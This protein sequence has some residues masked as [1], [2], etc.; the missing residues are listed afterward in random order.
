MEGRRQ[1]MELRH[2][3]RFHAMKSIQAGIRHWQHVVLYAWAVT[4]AESQQE[5][6]HMRQLE[7]L[8]A[9]ENAALEEA[10][11]EKAA[12]EQALVAESCRVDLQLKE[13]QHIWRAAEQTQTAELE[14]PTFAEACHAE[15]LR[16][17][18]ASA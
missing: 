2:Q 11:Q 4:T 18:V 7:L 17:E 15:A 16:T 14:A 6:Q 9:Q 5:E 8:A 3:R 13:M 10:A 12:L 1:T